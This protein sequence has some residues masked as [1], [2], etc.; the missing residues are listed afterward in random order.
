MISLFMCACCWFAF[1]CFF[2]TCRL[3]WT[4]GALVSMATMVATKTTTINNNERQPPN[5]YLV[6]KCLSVCVCVCV[7]MCLLAC[8]RIHID[9][10]RIWHTY[11][12]WYTRVN[13]I[14]SWLD[15]SFSLWII[16]CHYH[17]LCVYLYIGTDRIRN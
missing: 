9:F 17:R 7:S 8:I 12:I 1:C 6:R 4:I 2:F 5:G 16:Y 14:Y 11:A 15:A 10:I 13:L 3:H